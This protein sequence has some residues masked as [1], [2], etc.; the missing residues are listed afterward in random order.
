MSVLFRSLLV[1]GFLV[2]LF[3]LGKLFIDPDLSMPLY[4]I[5]ASVRAG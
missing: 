3:Q 2:Q 1:P 4:F 5:G